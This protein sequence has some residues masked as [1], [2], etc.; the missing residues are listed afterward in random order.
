MLFH[1][2]RL[3]LHQFL[4]EW[5]INE[6]DVTMPCDSVAHGNHCWIT[7]LM[8][9]IIIRVDPNL[10]PP[11]NEIGSGVYWILLVRPFLHPSGVYWIL[12]VRPFL[13]PSVHPSVWRWHGFR[14]V[15]Q[16]CCGISILT[17]ICMFF[18][19]MG[20]SLFNFSNVTLK[21]AAWQ[22]C[23]IFRSRL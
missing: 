10:M 3:P 8:K 22:P 11:P 5:T 19:A 7:S 14:S 18:V 15:T 6:F 21:M 13:H 12:L 2:W 4:C 23:W 16:V 17:F 1:K 20:R 9:K